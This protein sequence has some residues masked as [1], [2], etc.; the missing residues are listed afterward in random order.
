MAF[1]PVG[2]AARRLVSRLSVSLHERKRAADN[3][4]LPPEAARV[5]EDAKAPA[6]AKAAVAKRGRKAK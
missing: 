2:I 3:D 6:L 1:E 4:N 5:G